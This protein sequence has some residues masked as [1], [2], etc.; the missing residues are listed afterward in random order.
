[1][2][3]WLNEGS[4]WLVWLGIGSLLSFVLTLAVVPVL[5]VR[6]PADYF[7]AEKRQPVASGHWLLRTLLRALKNLL[8][9][10][11]VAVGIVLLVLPGQG[12]LTI[13]LGLGLLDFPGKYRLERRLISLPRLRHGIDWLR[14]RYGRPPLQ[15]EPE[16]RA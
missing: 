3:A 11:L 14:R 7:L 1:M 12:L 5:I 13:L 10:T 4:A 16:S 15:L 8:G 2:S 6:L 9:A